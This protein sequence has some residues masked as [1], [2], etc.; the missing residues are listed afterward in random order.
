MT[1]KSV[2][3]GRTSEGYLARPD[4]LARPSSRGIRVLIKTGFSGQFAMAL[5]S[6]HGF[7]RGERRIH[8]ADVRAAA[9]DVALDPLLDLVKARVRVLVEQGFAGGDKT[10]GAVAA[11]E[12]V[13]F[14]EGVWHAFLPGV[15]AFQSL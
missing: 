11:H 14:V 15:K 6:F 7:G 2:P 12:R 3:S 10:G 13:V 1:P 9:A 5:G 8:D 4:A